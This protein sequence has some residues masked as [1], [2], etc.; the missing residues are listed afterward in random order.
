MDI[1]RIM[2]MREERGEYET[3]HPMDS[4]VTSVLIE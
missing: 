2:T 1:T 4:F 3:R